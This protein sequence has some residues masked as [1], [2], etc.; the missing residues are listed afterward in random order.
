MRDTIEALKTKNQE[1]QEVIQGA[2]NIHETA[3]KGGCLR[4]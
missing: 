2:L 3:P 1:A 4:C